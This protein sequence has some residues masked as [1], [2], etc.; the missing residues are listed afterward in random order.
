MLSLVDP[1]RPNVPQ[2]IKE[3]SEAGIKVF[4]VTGDH[5]ITAHSIAKS[6][7]IITYKTSVELAEIGDFDTEAKAIVI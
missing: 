5:P 7:G 4:M 2:A 3:C 1:P 6:L